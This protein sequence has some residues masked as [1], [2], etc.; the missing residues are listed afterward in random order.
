M[1]SRSIHHFKQDIRINITLRGF[2]LTFYS[3]WGLFS[4]REIDEGSALLIDN[5]EVA[6]SDKLL[7]IGCGWGVIGLT[8]AKLASQGKVHL[9]DK[10]YVAIDY[11]KKNARIN[12]IDNC[13]IYL[14]NGFSNVPD[15]QF[16]T[17]VSNLPAKV[18]K[19][20]FWIILHDAKTHLRPGGKLYV[21]TISG[22]KE[23]IK[24]NFKEI[25]GN[26]EKVAQNKTY[27]VFLARNTSP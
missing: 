14:S 4:P 18:G 13:E 12:H 25:I 24:R 11:A 26:Y 2:P 23:F 5:V 10:D 6:S 20:L 16:D 19:E 22:L 7:D 8:L 21:V 9:I 15:V 1:D 3:T 27:S 17:I